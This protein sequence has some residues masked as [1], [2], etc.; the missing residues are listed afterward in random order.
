MIG[1]ARAGAARN[2]ARCVALGPQSA[3]PRGRDPV[4]YRCVTDEIRVNIE[5]T[6]GFT[7][8]S[9]KD[10]L[11]LPI[12]AVDSFILTVLRCGVS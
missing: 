4:C 12:S 10:A 2:S 8:I 5:K 3:G 1:S 11:G 7:V 9:T 6:A